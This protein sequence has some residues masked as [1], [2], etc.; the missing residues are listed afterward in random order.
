MQDFRFRWY[1]LTQS[2]FRVAYVKLY[3]I[4]EFLCRRKFSPKPTHLE[5][6]TA[7]KST[8]SRIIGS[9]KFRAKSAILNPA[10]WTPQPHP[11]DFSSSIRETPWNFRVFTSWDFFHEIK[12][13]RRTRSFKIHVSRIVGFCILLDLNRGGSEGCP[14]CQETMPTRFSALWARTNPLHTH[15]PPTGACQ[16]LCGGAA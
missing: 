12:P 10:V 3:E 14:R 4:L 5:E 9:C 1:N 15:P 6:P 13:S 2:I 7:S 8:V 16:V 11:I